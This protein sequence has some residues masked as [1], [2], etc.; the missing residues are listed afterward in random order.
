M[1]CNSDYTMLYLNKSG[2]RL[3]TRP[4]VFAR[5]DGHRP[6]KSHAG[7]SRVSRLAGDSRGLVKLLVS[8]DH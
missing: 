6:S 1:T 2:V 8:D 5:E 4:L 3:A 7:D